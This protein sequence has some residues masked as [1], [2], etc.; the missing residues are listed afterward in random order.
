MKKKNLLGLA[1]LPLAFLAGC[2]GTASLGFSPNWYY[3][4]TVEN[5]GGKSER[6]EYEVTFKENATED[7]SV[8]YEKGSYV[9]ELTPD[10]YESKQVYRFHTEYRIAG[11]Y[12]YGGES[13]D[14]FEDSMIS[15]VWFTK[16]SEGLLPL[17]SQKTVHA[18]VP[19][20]GSSDDRY[21]TYEF[22]YKL[23]YAPDLSDAEYTLDVTA[24]EAR[25]DRGKVKL[26]YSGT[27]LDNEEIVVA[28][29]GANLP[30]SGTAYPFMTIDPQTQ[31]AVRVNL[32]AESQSAAVG[33]ELNGEQIG[34]N[35]DAVRVSVS[36]DMDQPGPTREF[37]YAARKDEASKKYR[38]VL[39]S[40]KNTVMYNLGTMTYTLK[41]ATITD[42]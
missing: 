31:K 12:N 20:F 32:T 23:V 13:G 34:G 38:S 7:I 33:F 10:I 18:T 4:N 27:V 36:Y 14:R 17:E 16:A 11:Q 29:R 37:V 24:P 1:I 22:T 21:T 19:V 3:D 35:I 40:F 25:K 2:G 8:H 28:L 26:G 30:S 9:T 42:K 6:L 5:L 39:L 15:D 41:K